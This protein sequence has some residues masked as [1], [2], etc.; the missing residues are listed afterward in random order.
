MA[1]SSVKAVYLIL[2]TKNGQVSIFSVLY[3][4]DIFDVRS[5]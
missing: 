1:L 2:D 4:A 5:G 3:S